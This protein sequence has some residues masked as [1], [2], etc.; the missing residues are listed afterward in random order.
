M[1]LGLLAGFPLTVLGFW[2]WIFGSGTYDLGGWVLPL[3]VGM[4]L[5]GAV[6]GVVTGLRRG[7]WQTRGVYGTYV[8]SGAVLILCVALIGLQVGASRQRGRAEVSFQ[9][10]SA[11]GR[12][13]VSGTNGGRVVV[14]DTAT[15]RAIWESEG[16]PDVR[17]NHAT[18]SSGGERVAMAWED[19]TVRIDDA[20]T[21][22][23]VS[24]LDGAGTVI[25]MAFHPDSQRLATSSF[26]RTL[27][28]WDVRTQKPVK[29]RQIQTERFPVVFSPE[30]SRL[31]TVNQRKVQILDDVWD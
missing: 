22:Q 27:N 24:T 20:S 1:R 18:F 8:G 11:D 21:G 26:E 19:G 7:R 5:L 29:S 4:P 23:P 2:C 31:A 10:F 28:V 13:L 15:G 16:Q 30:G 9:G 12:R 14:W 3:G 17:A 25:Q 6:L